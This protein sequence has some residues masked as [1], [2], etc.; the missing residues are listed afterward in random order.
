MS[1]LLAASE[2]QGPPY[3][4]LYIGLLPAD[5][6]V[7]HQRIALRFDE[8][9]LAGLDD[10]VHAL[11]R[12]YRLSLDL[13]SMRCVGYRQA[14]EGLEKGEP[15]SLW[16]EKAIAATRQLAKRQLTWLRSMP[17]RQ[18]VACDAPDALEQVLKLA[19]QAIKPRLPATP[20]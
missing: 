12:K 6:A 17:W 3:D 7:L 11:R 4:L 19:G 13:P 1:E 14:W 2:R 20:T 18:R 5:R 16:R 15:L 8:M 9:L 10:E